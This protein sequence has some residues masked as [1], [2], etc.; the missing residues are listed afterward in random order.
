MLL[1]TINH[2]NNNNNVCWITIHIIPKAYMFVVCC[3]LLFVFCCC[4]LFVVCSCLLF[5][6]GYSLLLVVLC[7]W[8]FVRSDTG[9]W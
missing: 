2:C 9:R 1:V 6:V 4:L 3:L 7:C 5:V 8:L